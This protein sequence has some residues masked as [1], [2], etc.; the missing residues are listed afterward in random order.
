MI[1]CGAQWCIWV[2]DHMPQYKC[3][4]DLH[5]LAFWYPHCWAQTNP[6]Q[7][8][9]DSSLFWHLSDGT[10]SRPMSGQRNHS[11]S[12]AKDSR[13]ICSDLTST[14]HSYRTSSPSSIC[15]TPPA[16]G[17]QNSCMTGSSM[18]SWGNMSLI[19]TWSPQG[20]V[21]SPLRLQYQSVKLRKFADGTM[22]IG[23]ISGRDESSDRWEIDHLVTWCSQNNLELNTLKTVESVESCRFLGTTIT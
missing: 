2:R 10:N 15:L 21:L 9:C 23:V 17:S 1:S 7:R 12:S 18:W 5:Q 8:S 11:P 19:S 22:L 20:C 14:P 6:S 3:F 13:L 16:G 4:A